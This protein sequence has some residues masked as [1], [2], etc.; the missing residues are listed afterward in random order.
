[1]STFLRWL[2][3]GSDDLVLPQSWLDSPTLRQYEVYTATQLQQ[4]S[5]VSDVAAMR[6]KAFWAMID[7]KQTPQEPS[8][9]LKVVN[10]RFP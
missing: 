6:R 4:G 7:A 2:V 8:R 10:G 5:I 3:R 1:M 9:A